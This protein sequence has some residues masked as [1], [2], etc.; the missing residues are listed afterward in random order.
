MR[1]ITTHVINPVNDRLKITVRDEP[2]AGGA[3]H[4]YEIALPDGS[5]VRIGFQNGP[6]NEVGVNGLTHEALLAIIADRLVSFQLGPFCCDENQRALDGVNEAM[7]ALASRTRARM[8][9][10]VE[11]M[12]VA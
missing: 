3:N 8:V 11:G 10:G 4:D 5:G 12:N 7:D 1:E 2:G 9:R 6:I